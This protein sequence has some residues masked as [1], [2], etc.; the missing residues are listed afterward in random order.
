MSRIKQVIQRFIKL[1]EPLTS[2]DVAAH[3]IDHAVCTHTAGLAYRNESGAINEGLSDIWGACVEAY[4][5]NDKET[6]LIGEDIDLRAG[7]VALRSMSNPNAENQPDTYDG[8]NWYSQVGCTPSRFNDYCGVHTNSGVMNYWFY[9]LT[10]GGSGTN[11]IGNSF[12]VTGIGITSAAEITYRA[13]SVYMTSGTTYADARTH[14]I[15]SAEDLFGT[16]SQE[17]SIVISAWYA[18]GV[19][20]CTNE[21]FENTTVITSTTVRGCNIEVE[22]VSV[23]NGSKLILDSENETT[24]KGSFEVELGSELEIK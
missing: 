11:D 1:R 8:T 16:N 12:Q 21:I 23:T 14:T 3:E 19:G 24:I 2:I 22:N 9:L 13:E 7:H 10:E 20:V 6:W 17:V 18:V 4:A 5:T 15:Q